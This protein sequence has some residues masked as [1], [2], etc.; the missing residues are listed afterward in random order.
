LQVFQLKSQNLAGAQAIEKHQAD[1]REI[2]IG[3]ETLPEHC[4]FLRRKG[5]DDP[6]I[7][8]QAEAQGD[9]AAGSANPERGSLGI[10]VLEVN[11]AS[12][13]LSAGVEAVAA[14]H[15]LQAMVHGC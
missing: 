4:H 6:A 10:A 9:G 5:H 7:L 8:L 13:N 14:T 3:T 1:Q 12:G 15:H 2:A 11:G